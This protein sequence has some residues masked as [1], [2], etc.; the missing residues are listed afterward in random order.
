MRSIRIYWYLLGVALLSACAPL[1]P[2]RGKDILWVDPTAPGQ[3]ARG[4]GFSS[5]YTPSVSRDSTGDQV[6]VS[7]TETNGAHKLILVS[8]DAIR[9][10]DLPTRGS[11]LD[12]AGLPF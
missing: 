1:K 10:K 5:R 11:F 9:V 12:D 8:A 2:P 4:L 7:F 6:F 3:I